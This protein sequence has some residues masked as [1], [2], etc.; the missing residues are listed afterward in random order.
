VKEKSQLM[1]LLLLLVVVAIN[2]VS[3]LIQVAA[4]R[5]INFFF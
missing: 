5:W 3:I 1:L 2:L 4:I